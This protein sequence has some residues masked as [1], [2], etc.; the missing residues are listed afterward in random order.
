ML[1]TIA[2]QI[3][4]LTID[5]SP[6]LDTPEVHRRSHMLRGAV[7]HVLTTVADIQ[8]LAGKLDALAGIRTADIDEP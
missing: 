4:R 8:M 3:A 7:T 2:E 1:E 6:H 5:L